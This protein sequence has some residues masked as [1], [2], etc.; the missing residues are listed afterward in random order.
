MFEI[1]KNNLLQQMKTMKPILFLIAMNLFPIFIQAQNWEEPSEKPT[2]SYVHKIDIN[3]ENIDGDIKNNVFTD[4]LGNNNDI[5]ITQKNTGIHTQH[6][7]ATQSGDANQFYLIQEGYEN[8]ISADQNGSLNSMDIGIYGHNNHFEYSQDGDLNKLNHK[9]NL[10]NG[11]GG[12]RQTG[13]NNEIRL[14]ESGSNYLNG[15]T[16]QQTGGMRV[17]IT[18]SLKV[19]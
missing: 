8:S 9:T 14:D 19:K 3:K 7:S 2:S 5:K 18:T 12:I 10:N 4:Q 1:L 16:V 6:T 13:N 17:N 15:I 11:S